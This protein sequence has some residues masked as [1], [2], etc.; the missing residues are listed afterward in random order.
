M[1]ENHFT[2]LPLVV[3]EQYMALVKENDLLEWDTP[4]SPL[5]A[6]DFLHYRPAVFANG[7]PY[8]ALRIAHEHNLSVIP[9]VDSEN[10]YMGA[11]TKDELLKYVTEN[12]G[13][14]NPGSIIVLEVEPHSYSLLEIARLSENE[15]VVI[16]NSQLFSNRLTGKLEITLK[17]NRTDIRGLI[18]AFERHNYTVKEVYGEQT[19]YEDVVNRYKLLMNFINM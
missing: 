14:D 17:T 10:K 5:S 6:A 16:L 7:H 2:Q 15:N 3:N 18:S 8:E 1:E 4:E 13:I 9:V 19:L 12:S 11:I